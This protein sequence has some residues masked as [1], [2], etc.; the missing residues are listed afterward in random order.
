MRAESID[1]T[2]SLT[3]TSGGHQQDMGRAREKRKQVIKRPSQHSQS[4]Q[5]NAKLR[6]EEEKRQKILKKKGPVVVDMDVDSIG[7]GRSTASLDSST[8]EEARLARKKDNAHKV[9]SYKKFNASSTY[10]KHGPRAV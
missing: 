10:S 6:R 7:G 8:K 5:K 2:I 1:F 9:A 4:L 3:P